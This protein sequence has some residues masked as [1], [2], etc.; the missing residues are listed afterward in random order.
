MLDEFDRELTRRGLRFVR[1]AD[2]CNIFVR[3]ARA[4]QR[5]MGSI[6]KS[7]QGRLRLL[8]S[9]EN[10]R[11]ARPDEVHFLGFRLRKAKERTKVEPHVSNR[12]KE[13]MDA[14]IREGVTRTSRP[15][16]EPVCLLGLVLCFRSV[17]FGGSVP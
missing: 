2:D 6:R 13:R 8:V 12:T 10:S 16:V 5:L 7:F 14:K 15:V 4:G 9:E 1:C 11:I 3:S 17:G